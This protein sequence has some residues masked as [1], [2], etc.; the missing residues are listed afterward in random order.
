MIVLKYETQSL[1]QIL[2]LLDENRKLNGRFVDESF[3]LRSKIEK[4]DATVQE[5][6]EQIE[7]LESKIS[8]QTDYD[9]LKRELR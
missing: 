8:A 6:C 1:I 9:D 3:E 7:M 4:L 2:Q 5:K